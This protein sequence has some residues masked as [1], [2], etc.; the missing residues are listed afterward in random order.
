MAVCQDG[1]IS[2]DDEGRAK[3]QKGRKKLRTSVNALICA[4]V[5]LFLFQRV[6]LLALMLVSTAASLNKRLYYLWRC[7]KMARRVM[8]R[9]GRAQEGRAEKVLLL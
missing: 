1:E 9:K 6:A 8:M 4:C 7:F 2:E 3:F 5:I